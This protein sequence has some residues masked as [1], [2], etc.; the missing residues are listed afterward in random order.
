METAVKKRHGYFSGHGL[1][2]VLK[3]FRLVDEKGLSEIEQA[4]MVGIYLLEMNASAV[5]KYIV[6]KPSHK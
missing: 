1:D 6:R 3:M 4:L 5:R 2:S